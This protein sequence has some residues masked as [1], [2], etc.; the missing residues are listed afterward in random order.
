[1]RVK[2]LIGQLQALE[3]EA[4]VMVETKVTRGKEVEAVGDLERVSVAPFEYF[5]DD[6][7]AHSLVTL[8]CPS[9]EDVDA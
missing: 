4:E 5:V 1:M 3:P 8:H 2:E 7:D 9:A 6:R